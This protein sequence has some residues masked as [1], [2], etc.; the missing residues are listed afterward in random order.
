MQQTCTCA[1][2]EFDIPINVDVF[3]RCALHMADPKRCQRRRFCSC[4][5]VVHTTCA[6]LCRARCYRGCSL[7]WS[8]ELRSPSQTLN[9]RY[10]QGPQQVSQS[11]TST[12]T[13]SSTH[14]VGQYDSHYSSHQRTLKCQQS[15][16]LTQSRHMLAENSS[17]DT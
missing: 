2:S 7:A 16:A 10:E 8:F 9:L 14:F 15:S 4:A 17:F 3:P 5:R 12:E 13:A 1:P 6:C 11:D